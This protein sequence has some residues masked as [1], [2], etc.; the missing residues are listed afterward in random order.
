MNRVNAATAVPLIRYI[1]AQRSIFLDDWNYAFVS[2]LDK[3]A[4]DAAW[5]VLRNPPPGPVQTRLATFV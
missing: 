1:E 4:L 3:P 5:N 2:T